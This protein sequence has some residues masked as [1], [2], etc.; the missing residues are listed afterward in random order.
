MMRAEA[1]IGYRRPA[2]SAS[3]TRA[4]INTLPMS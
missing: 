1:V 3:M 4:V 2:S